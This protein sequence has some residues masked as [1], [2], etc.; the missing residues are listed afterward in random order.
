[1]QFIFHLQSFL[2]ITDSGY[3][4]H[5]IVGL[6]IGGLIAYL[7]YKQ[8]S[9]KIK[10]FVFGILIATLIGILKEFL[11]PYMR[12]NVDRYDLIYT[13]LGSVFGSFIILSKKSFWR[14]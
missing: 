6:L 14:Q 3:F 12:G 7:I 13:F 1:M 9:N 8:T 5:I 11:D 10:S 2:Q 4:E